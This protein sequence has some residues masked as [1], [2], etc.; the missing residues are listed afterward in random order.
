MSWSPHRLRG[1]P[2]QPRAPAPPPAW[3]RRPRPASGSGRPGAGDGAR[4]ATLLDGAGR[5]WPWTPCA[6]P[7]GMRN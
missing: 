7:A 3:A 2:A 1:P 6:P 4:G 5:R